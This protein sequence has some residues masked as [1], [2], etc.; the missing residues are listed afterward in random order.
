MAVVD[1]SL[2]IVANTVEDVSYRVRKFGFGDGYEQIAVDGI[3][4]RTIEYNITTRPLDRADSNSLQGILDKAAVGDLLQIT[5]EPYTAE[6][7]LY[8]LK[9]SQYSRQLLRYT[10]RSGQQEL[11][12]TVYTFTLVEAHG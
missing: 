7:R 3:N 2:D 4:P 12:K 10:A 1:L 8:R 6:E 9:D 5:L 11:S